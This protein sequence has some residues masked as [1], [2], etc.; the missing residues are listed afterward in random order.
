MD[1]VELLSRCVGVNKATDVSPR[2]FTLEALNVA[3]E[4]RSW[5]TKD[6]IKWF[7][8][9]DNER[10]ANRLDGC[11]EQL[12]IDG[13]TLLSLA[14]N[15]EWLRNQIGLHDD[16]ER[17]IV[18]H[19]LHK[20][21]LESGAILFNHH[22][23]Y[24][25]AMDTLL[26]LLRDNEENCKVMQKKKKM[27]RNQMDEDSVS[28]ILASLNAEKE[29]YEFRLNILEA[30]QQMINDSHPAATNIKNSWHELGGFATVLSLFTS[31]DSLWPDCDERTSQ[32]AMELIE[33]SFTMIISV[34][35]NHPRNRTYFWFSSWNSIADAIIV[36]GVLK[37][38]HCKTL[39][40]I[41]FA[42]AMEELFLDVD[43]G[44]RKPSHLGVVAV[45]SSQQQQSQLRNQK[46]KEYLIT[47][48]FY[49]PNWN[50]DNE[51]NLS[52]ESKTLESNF[53]KN[54]EAILVILKILSLCPEQ[55]QLHIFEKLLS[56]I[57]LYVIDSNG[58]KWTI[59]Q[60]YDLYSEILESSANTPLRRV[61][62][63]FIVGMF[64][65]FLNFISSSSS[66]G[67]IFLNQCIYS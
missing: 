29:S 9:V 37:S 66:F 50:D 31:L 59:Q 13:Q 38:T 19:A 20:L 5:T 12:Q 40:R 47:H 15:D 39:F 25:L 27:I 62:N 35:K 43:G 49:N 58:Y 30:L 57:N 34:I 14:N 42:L 51:Y 61:L 36:T 8:T 53:L 2:Y 28:D 17:S 1:H 7:R 32:L 65:C 4:I 54:P 26:N 6:V 44:H 45:A 55:L 16:V 52:N 23:L 22:D 63:Q 11:I 3:F 48:S 33:K 60:V 46:E 18:Q 41:L 21:K 10:F 56:L 64:I 67:S 24:V